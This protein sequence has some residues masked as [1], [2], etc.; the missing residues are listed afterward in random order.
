MSDKLKPEDGFENVP[1]P[2]RVSE[3]KR[4]ATSQDEQSPGN[5]GG[6]IGQKAENAEPSIGDSEPD[7]ADDGERSTKADEKIS[8]SDARAAAAE[9]ANAEIRAKMLELGN[10]IY[11]MSRDAEF[12]TSA[13]VSA[14]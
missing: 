13:S 7:P 8:A 3:N 10:Q 2:E 11:R 12:R 5:D 9:A 6:K 1:T 4:G 14:A